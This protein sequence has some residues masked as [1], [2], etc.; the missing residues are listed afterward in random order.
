MAAVGGQERCCGAQLW[1]QCQHKVMSAEAVG[2]TLG[3]I[4]RSGV[5]V[6]MD[7]GRK[8]S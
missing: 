5:E 4:Q 3:E 7:Q 8:D 1:E 6:E 2:H